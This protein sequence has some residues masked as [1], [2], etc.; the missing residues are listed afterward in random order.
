[1]ALVLL[2]FPQLRKQR[3]EEALYF[4]FSLQ[5]SFHNQPWATDI[6][7]LSI[8]PDSLCPPHLTPAL[9]VIL[10]APDIWKIRNER[11]N[12]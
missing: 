10:C 4:F 7:M 6:L 1:M 9:W 8:M 2:A 3:Q 11:V 5:P 12:E